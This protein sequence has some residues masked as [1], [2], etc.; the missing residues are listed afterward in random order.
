MGGREGRRIARG[1]GRN[2]RP[3]S[4]DGEPTTMREPNVPNRPLFRSAFSRGLTGTL[5][6]YSTI[7][8][9]YACGSNESHASSGREVREVEWGKVIDGGN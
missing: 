5:V 2:G 7:R 8:C 9:V 6:E 4:A 3:L 1:K